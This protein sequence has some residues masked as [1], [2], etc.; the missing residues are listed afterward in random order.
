MA[1]DRGINGQNNFSLQALAI[2]FNLFPVRYMHSSWL[3]KDK[4]YKLIMSLKDNPETHLPLS[5]HLLKQFK[6][7]NDLDFDF[8]AKEKRVVLA[9]MEEL[10]RLAFYLGII[11]HEETI[12]SVVLRKERVALEHVLGKEAYQFAVRKAQFISRASRHA[13]P[14]LLIDWEHL[15]RFKHYLMTSGIQVIGCAFSRTPAAFQKRLAIKV[16]ADWRQALSS[17]GEIQLEP[18]QC[19][20]LMVKTHKEVNRQWRNLLS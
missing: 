4:H 2:E 9:N 18:S 19:A 6:L 17:K 10:S 13:V 5:E 7:S 15:D 11:L 1:P 16:P 3:K 12:R 14:S 20:Q 8:E